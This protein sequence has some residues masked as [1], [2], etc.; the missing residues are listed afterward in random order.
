[1]LGLPMKIH[2][3]CF[4]HMVAINQYDIFAVMLRDGW[5][6]MLLCESLRLRFGK[7]VPR[8]PVVEQVEP[9]F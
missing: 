7:S 9:A 1:M 6:S 2:C 4:C 3:H 8:L 5:L